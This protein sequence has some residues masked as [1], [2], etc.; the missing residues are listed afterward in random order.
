MRKYKPVSDHK[1]D[2]NK[3]VD[4][5]AKKFILCNGAFVFL[6]KCLL[7]VIVVLVNCNILK[8]YKDSLRYKE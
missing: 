4:P 7:N 1:N 8:I 5:P 6:I 2:S 3:R